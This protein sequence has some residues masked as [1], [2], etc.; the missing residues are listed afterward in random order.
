MTPE[1]RFTR[2]ETILRSVTEQQATTQQQLRIHGQEIEKQNEGIRGLIVVA[3]TCLDSF[4]E[5]REGI[6]ELRASIRELREAQATTDE[7]L[8]ILIETVDRIIRNRNGKE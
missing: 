5:V 4:T 3:R 6:Q 8:N 2:I 7:R 1:E